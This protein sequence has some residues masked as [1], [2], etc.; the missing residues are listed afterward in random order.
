VDK[1]AAMI[2]RYHATTVCVDY[3]SLMQ[4]TIKSKAADWERVKAISN[5]LKALARQTKVKLY[6]AAQN[7]KDAVLN[8]P[9]EE[10]IAYSTAV[11]QDCNVLIGWHQDAEMARVDKMQGRLIKNRRGEKGPPGDSGYYEFYEKWDRDRM[12]MEPWNEA[13]HNWDLK[14]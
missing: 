2:E 5:E 13:V 9:T 11:V 3:I 4:P 8:G 10:N 6:V 1:L 7:S 12:I 14:A